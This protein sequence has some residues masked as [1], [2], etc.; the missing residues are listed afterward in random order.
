MA[1]IG[2]VRRGWVRQARHGADG[3]VE[4]RSGEAGEAW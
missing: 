3:Y 1:R 2:A 4:A